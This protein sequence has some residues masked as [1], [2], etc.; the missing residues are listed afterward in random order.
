MYFVLSYIV[1]RAVS[2]EIYTAG[3]NFTLPLAVTALTNFTSGQRYR[4]RPLT[5]SI[6]PKCHQPY[7]LIAN[8]D[9]NIY[10]I[11]FSQRPD[12][13]FY[14]IMSLTWN[15]QILCEE[16]QTNL[17]RNLVTAQ[18]GQSLQ[19]W[20]NERICSGRTAPFASAPTPLCCMYSVKYVWSPNK[21]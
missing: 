3:K 20:D 2:G 8:L 10:K 13:E 5:R 9:Y 4:D 1:N 19:L 14:R 15:L 21:I 18:F 12:I 6:C 16:M 11:L 17:G 7:H